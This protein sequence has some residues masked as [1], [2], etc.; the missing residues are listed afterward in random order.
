MFALLF[1]LEPFQAFD[2]ER[3]RKTVSLIDRAV[4]GAADAI[5]AGEALTLSDGV[6]LGA[7]ASGW[8][9]SHPSDDEETV[10][11]Q[12]FG[13]NVDPRDSLGEFR[14]DWVLEHYAYRTDSLLRRLV[15]HQ[16]SL[17]VLGVVDT[18]AATSVVGCVL[19]CDDPIAAYVAMNA[20]IDHYLAA[21]EQLGERVASHLMAAEMALRRTRRAATQD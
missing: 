4:H 11:Q 8:R 10:L 12:A 1:S 15:P 18:L 2:H 5:E 9:E 6:A 19:D 16:A 21:P 13:T 3:A 17:G 20:F 7:V 14:A